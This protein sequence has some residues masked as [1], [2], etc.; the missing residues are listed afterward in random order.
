MSNVSHSLTAPAVHAGSPALNLGLIYTLCVP[1]LA[2]VATVR[3]VDIAG[4]NYGGVLWVIAF[5]IGVLL[6]LHSAIQPGQRVHFPVWPWSLWLGY[7]GLSFLWLDEPSYL[8]AQYALQ[9]SMP[10]LVGILAS[11]SVRTRPQL[12]LLVRFYFLSLLLLLGFVGLCVVGVLSQDEMDPVFVAVRPL[13]LTAVVVGGLFI[14][15]SKRNFS[16]AWLGWAV[17]LAITV[18]TGSRMASLAMLTLPILNPVTRNPLRMAAAILVVGLVG[19]SV[20]S[21]S[22]FQERFFRDK[23]GG[24][25][26]IASG[27]F[28][29]SGR[30]RSWPLLLEE[31]LERPWVGHG[32]GSVQIFVPSVWPEATH[33]MNDYLRVLF[34]LG[35]VGLMLFFGA[36]G[37]QL[38]NLGREI[39]RTTGIV[40]QALGC[41]WLGLAAF[42]L[43]AITD[44]PIIYNVGYMDP[45]FAL[46]GAA[47]A[48]AREEELDCGW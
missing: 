13:S 10:V 2:G 45:V 26:E 37:W 7:M 48:V 43:V 23:A 24:L 12:E 46:M 44:N 41:A 15:G 9:L 35:S 39:R 25:G 18:V 8:Q 27:D 29:S 28:D 47:Y 42:L 38:W 3:G 5:V 22:I 40:Q 1:L 6:L 30:F 33:P 31:G 16:R 11:L 21:T 34:D 32:V 14:A 17:C 20:Y 36:L 19:I 4:Y